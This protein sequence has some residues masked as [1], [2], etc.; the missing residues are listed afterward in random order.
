MKYKVTAS[1]LAYY[2]LEVEADSEEQAF[3]IAKETDG[4]SFD[5]ETEGDW[6]I[7]NVEEIK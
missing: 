1:S 5:R 2:C 7:T 4:G 3:L 6:V